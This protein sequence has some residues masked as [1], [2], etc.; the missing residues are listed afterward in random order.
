MEADPTLYLAGRTGRLRLPAGPLIERDLPFVRIVD[1]Q[2]R[3]LE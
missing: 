1:G 3:P 2:V